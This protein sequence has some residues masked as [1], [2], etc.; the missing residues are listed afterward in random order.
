MWH[1]LVGDEWR[2]RSSSALESGCARRISFTKPLKNC[3]HGGVFF[4]LCQ[5]LFLIFLFHLNFYLMPIQFIDLLLVSNANPTII[6]VMILIKTAMDWCRNSWWGFPGQMLLQVSCSCTCSCSCC[7]QSQWA[8]ASVCLSSGGLSAAG[9]FL[10]GANTHKLALLQ[11]RK[12]N[13]WYEGRPRVFRFYL[14]DSRCGR[15][16]RENEWTRAETWTN[17]KA[18][19][20]L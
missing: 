19:T 9:C 4:T 5:F 20:S 11:Q 1:R 2:W 18:V 7:I 15:R 12:R 10:K 8:S 17:T 13:G 6:T 14:P 16:P 3:K